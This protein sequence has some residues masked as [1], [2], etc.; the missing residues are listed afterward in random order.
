MLYAILRT[1]ARL[2][3]RWF[4]RDIAVQGIDRIPAQGPLILAANHNNA[5]VDALIVAGVMD[6]EVRLT[7]KATLLDHPLTRVIV[8]AVG[9]VPLRRA[10]DESRAGNNNANASRNQ[11]AFEAI[12]Q[13]L[14]QGGIILIFPEGISHSAPMLAPLK[15]GCAR[16]AIQ[17][18]QQDIE[19][20]SIIPVGLTFEDKGRPRS[21]VAVLVGDPIPVNKALA[22][23]ANAVATITGALDEG[24]RRVTLNV[25]SHDEAVRVLDVSDT[26]SRAFE[27]VRSLDDPTPSFAETIQLAR[28]VEGVRRRLPALSTT[29]VA[30]VNQFVGDLD[31]W[32]NEARRLDTPI[33]D[34]GMPLSLGAGMWFALREGVMAALVGPIALWGRVNHLVPLKVAVWLGRVTSRNA[35]EPAMHTLVGGL[36]LLL[37]TYV[38]VAW[39]VGRWFGWPGAAVYLAS[40]PLAASLDFW[41][42]D[43]VHAAWRR[44]RGYLTLRSQPVRA[45]WLAEERL[46]LRKEALALGSLTD[47]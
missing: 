47:R 46:R 15:T 7:A 39:L 30:R 21:R 28:Q 18:V 33:G 35:D 6:R 5:L 10:A 32:T 43:R 2:A 19:S 41:W 9:I 1:I 20:L 8:H 44:A 40:L 38:L 23:E 37:A 12:V 24:L 25:P 22:S 11:G 29:E 17:A 27:D 34:V 13:R 14:A 3:L 36:V 31:R 45:K 42:R 16:I 26:L 4:Y